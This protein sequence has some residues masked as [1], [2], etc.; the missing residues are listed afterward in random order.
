VLAIG[1]LPGLRIDRT[2]AAIARASLMIGTGA[3][4]FDEAAWQAVDHRTLVLQDRRS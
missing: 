4:R 2:G 1:H 3:L